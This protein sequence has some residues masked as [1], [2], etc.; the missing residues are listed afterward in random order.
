MK[1][2]EKWKK[3]DRHKLTKMQRNQERLAY[4]FISPALLFFAVFV[5]AAIAMA[6]YFSFCSFS[7][8]NPTLKKWVWFDNYVEIFTAKGLAPFRKSLLHVLYYA[9][10]YVPLVVIMSMLFAVLVNQKLRGAKIFRVMYYIPSITSGVAVA[11]VFKF[12]FDSA[13]YGLMNTILGWFGGKPLDWLGTEGLAMFCIAIVNVW[14]GIGGNM[15]IYLAALQGVPPDQVEAAKVDGANRWEIFKH[16]TLPQ[17]AQATFFVVMMSLIGAFQ[18]YDQVNIMT[19]GGSGTNTPVFDIYMMAF[20]PGSV[21]SGMANAMAVV[22][23]V[24]IMIVTSLNNFVQNKINK[25]YE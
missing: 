24:F 11:F 19:G 5:V 17:I 13:D 14:G 2:L 15:I 23:F 16:I 6:V 8:N 12:L 25:K 9:V 21:R 22:L 10:M 20:D 1:L 18:L 3:R 7:F 4:L